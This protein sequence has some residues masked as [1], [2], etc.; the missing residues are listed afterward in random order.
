MNKYIDYRLV[1]VLCFFILLCSFYTCRSHELPQFPGKPCMMPQFPE[2]EVEE[3]TYSV[4]FLDYIRTRNYQRQRMIVDLPTQRVNYYNPP[5]FVAPPV[6]RSRSQTY[7][8]TYRQ[9]AP[10]YQ[11]PRFSPVNCGPSG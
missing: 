9:P 5:I 8:P 4:E 11:P 3:E 7:T 10:R 1:F 6:T 2:K